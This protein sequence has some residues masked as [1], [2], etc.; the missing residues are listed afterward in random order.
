MATESR[1]YRIGDVIGSLRDLI[2]RRRS[3]SLSRRRKRDVEMTTAA[4]ERERKVSAPADLNQIFTPVVEQPFTSSS[5]SMKYTLNSQRNSRVSPIRQV[6]VV[7]T[8]IP[9]V[10]P[11]QN[12]V[13]Y[14][15][16]D[17]SEGIV[18]L[19]SKKEV[20][21]TSI[22]DYSLVNGLFVRL[23]SNSL[24]LKHNIPT[25]SIDCSVVGEMISVPVFE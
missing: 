20:S 9:S 7:K 6:D 24:R 22:S 2:S 15:V 19:L 3:P 14:S 23:F 18:Q 10:M 8:I 16:P 17:G 21:V 11:T 5:D 1:P 12:N 25:L 4:I 13:Q